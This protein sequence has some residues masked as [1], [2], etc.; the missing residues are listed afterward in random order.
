MTTAPARDGAAGD[1]RVAAAA[2]TATRTA[3]PAGT[4]SRPRRSEVVRPKAG[5]RLPAA[6]AAGPPGAAPARMG[7]TPRRTRPRR[8]LRPTAPTPTPKPAGRRTPTATAR[9]RPA[10]GGG[11]ASAAVVRPGKAPTL[12]AR[13]TRRTP[14]CTCV[15]RTAAR[16][17]QPAQPA[18][19]SARS[20]VP[21]GWRPRS[22][23][24][25]R[26]G[27]PVGAARR[28]SPSRSSSPAA[29]RSSGPW[30]SASARTAPRSP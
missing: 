26:A 9:P 16:R 21:P 25:A 17:P 27:R 5:G 28:S 14:W 4:P 20:R 19:M 15:S 1:G 29:S 24:A 12:P 2:G 18:T 22:S 30:W 6:A 13:T 23:G 10:G 3:R 7:R 8:R 11:A